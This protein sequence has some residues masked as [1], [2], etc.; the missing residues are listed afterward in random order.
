MYYDPLIDV[1]H[2]LPV[3]AALTT[4]FYVAPQQSDEARRLFEAACRSARLDGDLDLPL[5]AGRGVPSSLVLAREWGM[6][7]LAER[8]AAAIEASYEP[9]WDHDRGEF[10][11]GMGLNEAYP[12]GQ[13]NA[14]LA[15][16][17]AGGPGRWT[18]LSA[19]P[20][21][22]C[23]QVVD[24]DFPRVALRQ[25]EWVGS[26]LRLNLAPLHPQPRQRTTFR[27]VGAAPGSWQIAGPEG[28]TV[29]STERGLIVDTLLV[30]G[31]IELAPSAVA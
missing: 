15:T 13:F 16:A 25:A 26:T 20:L 6:T 24:V 19:A 1:H 2:R 8:L 28:A 29:S 22:R 4:S 30:E 18:A 31:E 21:E 3:R 9:T 14:F 7:D 10:T 11:W 27:V 17:E 5:I 23:P 12:R